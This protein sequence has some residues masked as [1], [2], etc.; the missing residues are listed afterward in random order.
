[1]VCHLEGLP[2][3][4]SE[5]GVRKTIWLAYANGAFL[6]GGKALTKKFLFRA[7]SAKGGGCAFCSFFQRFPFGPVSV[8]PFVLAGF[9]VKVKNGPS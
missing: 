7:L 4:T 6:M 9:V 2:T 5:G 1:M 3:V 8:L